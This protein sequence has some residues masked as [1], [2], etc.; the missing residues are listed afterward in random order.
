MKPIL[1]TP[2]IS[3]S[4]GGTVPVILA[5]MNSLDLSASFPKGVWADRALVLGPLVGP[6][7]PLGIRKFVGV[8]D[9]FIG[10]NVIGEMSSVIDMLINSADDVGGYSTLHF[11]V[12]DLT[13]VDPLREWRVPIA[14]QGSF[15]VESSN[16]I[17]VEFIAV[18]AAPLDVGFNI[19]G[20]SAY[21]F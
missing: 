2:S 17:S 13:M 11:K 18:C 15:L 6:S 14:V 12:P 5:T 7:L 20:F 16:P 4:G 9:L 19:V 21:F 3:S 1:A 8:I 10:G